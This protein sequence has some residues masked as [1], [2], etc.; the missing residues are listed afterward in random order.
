[1]KY[2]HY[3]EY[4]L[5]PT[6]NSFEDKLRVLRKYVKI[7]K[8]VKGDRFQQNINLAERFFIIL[9]NYL[10]LEKGFYKELKEN[11]WEELNKYVNLIEQ[12]GD[13]DDE[14][15]FAIY[16][17]FLELY[18]P[19]SSYL[20][21]NIEKFTENDIIKKYIDKKPYIFEKLLNVNK[22]LEDIEQFKIISK[23]N[24]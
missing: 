14:D 7:L 18:D 10:I 4:I 21:A 11:N 1:M 22:T 15:R 5:I 23:Y 6:K 3:F 17:K 20:R 13:V 19:G 12:H 2:L 8:K 9:H 16:N 24:L